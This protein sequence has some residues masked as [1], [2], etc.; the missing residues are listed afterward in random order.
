MN[1]APIIPFI[2]PFIQHFSSKNQLLLLMILRIVIN[3]TIYPNL[4]RGFC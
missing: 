1:Y 4:L 3:R 2:P